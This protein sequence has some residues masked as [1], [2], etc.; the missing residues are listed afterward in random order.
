M[1]IPVVAV[2][3]AGTM[4]FTAGCATKKHV[5]RETG[6]IINKVNELDDL[7]SKTTRDIRE[8][9]QRATQG[10]QTAQ[11]KAEEA[12]K[13]AQQADQ[14]A[15]QAQQLAMNTNNNIGTLTERVANIDNYRPVLE[16]SV[17]FGFDRAD[18][19]RNAKQALDEI[20]AQIP[21]TKGYIVQI[22]GS[23][24]STGDPNYN[25]QLSQRRASA[26]IQY[27]ASQ[28]NV[29]ANKIY[30]IGLGEDKPVAKNASASGRA[31]NRRVDVRL[32]SNVSGQQPQQQQ[33]PA[34]T[35]VQ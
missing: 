23:T 20:A 22:E 35:A 19:D 3:L 27:L 11:S 24:D 31:E 2:I 26:V 32:M 6:P 8:V 9:D 33:Q 13:H 34:A 12:D 14:A 21:N 29:P 28:H 17:R 7:T 1:K 5:A 15:Q 4:A 16:S 10:I 18:L 25:Y 30:V